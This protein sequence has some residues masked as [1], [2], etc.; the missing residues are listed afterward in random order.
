MIERYTRAEMGRIWEDK[1]K[2]D[3]WLEI[4]VLS[5]EG[6]ARAGRIPRSTGARIR[7]KAS[8]DMARVHAREKV[9]RHD[10][11]AFVDVVGEKIGPLARYLHLGMTSSDVLDTCLAVQMVQAADIIIA[12]I[13]R[14]LKV[15]K[16]KAKRYKKTVMI[17]RSHGM[18]AEPVTFGLVMV[19]WYDEMRRNLERM[20]LARE[21]VRV[22][23]V[24]GAVGTYAHLDPKVE[25]YVMKKLGLRS[26]N[27][28]TQ[29]IQRDRHAEYLSTLALIGASLEKFALQVRHW[30]RTEVKEAEEFFRKGQKGSSAMPHKRNPVGSEN[31]AGL[32]RLLRANALAAFENVALWHERDI[33]HSSVERVIIPDST[34]ILDYMLN[35][36][37]GLIENLLVYPEN[38]RR[39][40]EMTRGLIFSEG[41][42]LALMEKGLRRDQAYA[43]VQRNAMRVFE[44]SDRDFKSMLLED[45]EIQTHLSRKE[46]EECFDL[47]RLL[48]HV[49]FIFQRVFR[50]GQ[51]VK[52]R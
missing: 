1:N 41:V 14:M 9:T 28:T 6:W 43:L 15:L 13:N 45:L 34:I 21:I 42:M 19:L 22:G 38:M 23:K 47:K 31:T 35:R 32:A 49:E 29:I 24:S 25:T 51:A 52:E 46:I 11:A 27:I 36:F 12:D 37:T 16:A 5:C 18:H 50:D 10:V 3:I 40:L 44:Q 17:G 39:N 4:E 26:P 7:Q 48:G 2:F 33:S 20:H 8:Y 30:Q